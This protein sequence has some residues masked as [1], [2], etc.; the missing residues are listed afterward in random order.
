M[1]VIHYKGKG[2]LTQEIEE[3]FNQHKIKFEIKKSIDAV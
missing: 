1:K 2:I 3:C